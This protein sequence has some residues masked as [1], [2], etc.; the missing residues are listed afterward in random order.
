MEE[1]SLSGTGQQETFN[2]RV[3]EHYFMS[4][5]FC[6]LTRSSKKKNSQLNFPQECDSYMALSVT[7]ASLFAG[8]VFND[9]IT[10]VAKNIHSFLTKVMYSRNNLVQSLKNSSLFV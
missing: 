5:N 3:L 4:L 8:G 6:G 1:Q 9:C 7:M 2:A 10:N